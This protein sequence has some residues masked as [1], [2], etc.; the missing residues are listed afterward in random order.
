MSVAW[1]R[2]DAPQEPEPHPWV[3][4]RAELRATLYEILDA[5]ILVLQ[6]TFGNIELYD[7]IRGVLKIVAQR[8]FREEF[9]QAMGTVP[10]NTGLA[11][12]RAIRNRKR[13][14]IPDVGEDPEYEPYRTLAANAGYRAVQ[15]TPMLSREGEVLGALVTHLPEARDFS[16]HELQVLDLYSRQAADAVVRTRVERDLA[17]ARSRLETALRVGEMGVYDWNM[18]TGRVYGDP[19]YR[20]IAAVPF[21]KDGFAQRKVLSDAIHPDD[22]EER[23]KRVHR[24]IET[25]EPYEAEYRIVSGGEPRWVMSRG[26]VDYD[27]TGKPTHFTGVLVDIT[28]RKQ[29]EDALLEAD[30][31]KNAFLAQLAHELR[32]P[33]APIRNA[34]RIFRLER[35]SPGDVE[36]ASDMI[37]RQ[38]QHLTRLIDDLL[39]VS[40]ISRNKLEL[41]RQ[42][43]ELKDIV[44]GAV[45]SSKPVIEQSGHE[46]IVHITPEPVFLFADS[47][48]LTQALINLLNN[49]AKYTDTG[50]RIELFAGCEDG[51]AVMRV[52]D[53][54]IGIE[55]AALAKVF[56]MFFQ[57]DSSLERAQGGL[58]IGL[59]LVKSVIELHGGSVEARS[60]GLGHG[61][62][63]M[64]RVPV[65][66]RAEPAS[67]R[68]AEADGRS[69]VAVARRVLIADDNRDAAESLALFL[70]VTGHIADTA[71]DGEQALEMAERMRPEIVF[72][73]LGMPRM[74]GYE[75]CRRIRATDWGK[76][77]IVIAQT[78]WGQEE[79]K[80]R[81]REAGFD[82]HFVKP[83][84]PTAVMKLIETV[85]EGRASQISAGQP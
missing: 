33:L 78:G 13:V 54:G 9:M 81:T 5:A 42:R 41:R 47:A 72:L 37:D 16:V 66:H 34:A 64:L 35:A 68:G 57:V 56:N 82:A 11:G 76:Q 45:D 29:A 8:G 62:Q 71:F 75:V 73:D 28:A 22:R 65:E 44:N 25:G 59:S 74:N 61:S 83:L 6:G 63:F 15:A 39:D 53:N 38:V 36:W 24:A 14:I 58:G 4:V 3:E 27:E 52:T 23:L 10:I 21:D 67:A 1:L 46:L 60:A 70:Q 79:D 80:R 17:T 30:R 50:G 49:A 51:Q 55:P 20:R 2:G 31:Q 18:L 7:P 43:T 69:E 26:M 40:R 85:N 12:A 19:N 84:D 32:N 77:I 48:R